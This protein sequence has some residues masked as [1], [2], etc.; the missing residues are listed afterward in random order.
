MEIKD[1]QQLA[2]SVLK[3]R[4]GFAPSRQKIAIIESAKDAHWMLIEVGG[5]R[6]EIRTDTLGG[7][8]VKQCK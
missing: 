5:K 7:Y 3:S 1:Q 4:Y 2:Q 8:G 6:Y